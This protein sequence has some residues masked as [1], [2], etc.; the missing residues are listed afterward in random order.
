M[1]QISILNI[2]KQLNKKDPIPKLSAQA[3]YLQEID[4]EQFFSPK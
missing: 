2:P 3:V 4:L 1:P